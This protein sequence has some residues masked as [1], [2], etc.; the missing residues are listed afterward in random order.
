MRRATL[1]LILACCHAAPQPT[2]MPHDEA[3]IVKLVH[4]LTEA[5]G[6]ND[7][8]TL[9]PLLRD[10]YLHTDIHGKTQDKAQWL[11]YMNDRR[12]RAI[13]NTVEVADEHVRFYGDVA[14]VTSEDLIGTPGEP[15]KVFRMR[16]TQVW[17]REP[18]GRW[19][20]AVFEGTPIATE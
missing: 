8:A 9:E 12:A 18:D 19:K 17:I 5:W 14:I 13:T 20:R 10:D 11:A 4:D 3:A 1:V 7:L 15:G 16:A 6:H 2:T